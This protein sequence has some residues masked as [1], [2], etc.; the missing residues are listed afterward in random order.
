[1]QSAYLSENRGPVRQLAAQS[2]QTIEHLSVLDG[3]QVAEI[4]KTR[5]HSAV[6][7][8]GNKNI[9]ISNKIQREFA[10]KSKTKVVLIVTS[11]AHIFR[12]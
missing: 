1:M 8:R 10:M 7:Y 4:L 9:Q 5:M 6:D 11:S 3:V 2:L 12:K